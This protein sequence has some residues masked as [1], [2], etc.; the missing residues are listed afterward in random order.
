MCLVLS[1][2]LSLW[3]SLWFLFIFVLFQ[4]WCHKNEI[5]R[6]NISFI[7]EREGGKM[8]IYTLTDW[9]IHMDWYIYTGW[10]AHISIYIYIYTNWLGCLYCLINL[11]KPVKKLVEFPTYLY[12]YTSSEWLMCICIKWLVYTKMGIAAV[13]VDSRRLVV[14]PGFIMQLL[15]VSCIICQTISSENHVI[16]WHSWKT[17]NGGNA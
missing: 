13:D 17:T 15:S 10:L 14:N 4:E 12:I 3:K 9:Y 11:Y 7:C 16:C 5:W 2:C 6:K 1:F 8:S